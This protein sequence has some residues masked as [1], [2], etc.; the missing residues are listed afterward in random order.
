MKCPK[1]G[2]TH[3]S[4]REV[5]KRSG[6]T[7]GSLLGAAVG[8]ATALRG[9]QVGATLGAV[10]GPI[11]M[12]AGGLTGAILTGLLAGSAGCAVGSVAGNMADANF[13]D[14]RG[15]LDCGHTFREDVAPTSVNVQYTP[16]T[17]RPASASDIEPHAPHAAGATHPNGA[18]QP[19]T[20]AMQFYED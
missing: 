8:T 6:A 12:V 5:G 11:G 16:G 2:S 9:A 10:G 18:G 3:I 20:V 13:L 7:M 15:C 19:S 1:C 4:N 14:N 17:A